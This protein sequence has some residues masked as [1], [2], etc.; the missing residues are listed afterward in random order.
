L[1]EI[2]IPGFKSLQIDNL[3]LDYNGTIACDGVVLPGVLDRIQSLTHQLDVHVITAD[4][5]GGVQSELKGVQCQVSVL[6]PGKE[7]LGKLEFV[8]TL[9]VERTICIGN[10]RNDKLMVK[11]AAVGIV[12]CQGEGLA[13]ESFIAADVICTSVL[14]ALALLI[15]PLR[16]VA[17]LRS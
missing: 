16:L 8:R 2:D 15:S 3:V 1:L 4:T 12:V 10:G 9:G 7:D 11:E 13:V 6:P 5:Y 14:D 17:T